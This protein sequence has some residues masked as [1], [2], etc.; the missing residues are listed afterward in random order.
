MFT[1]V[2]GVIGRGTE[3]VDV[4]LITE[5]AEHRLGCVHLGRL[6]FG[7]IASQFTV[8]VNGRFQVGADDVC[9][10]VEVRDVIEQVRGVFRGQDIDR[11]QVSGT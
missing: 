8:P 11:Q 2:Q 1:P 6:P 7:L 4:G 3:E 10:A 9:G 5:L